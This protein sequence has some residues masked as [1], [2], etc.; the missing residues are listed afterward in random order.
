M[1]G[2]ALLFFLVVALAILLAAAWWMYAVLDELK[3]INKE[4]TQRNQAANRQHQEMLSAVREA[5][6]MRS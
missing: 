6:Q 2:L 5:A 4:T 3:E 1:A